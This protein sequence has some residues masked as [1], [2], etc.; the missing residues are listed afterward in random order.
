ME[1]KQLGKHCTFE[2][3]KQFDVLPFTCDACKKV[4][5]KEH[6]SIYAHRCTEGASRDVR[7]P[8]CPLC[9]KPVSCPKGVKPDNAIK[10]HIDNDCQSDSGKR[11]VYKYNCS[12]KECK[13]REIIALK[14]KDCSLNY[15]LIHRHSDDHKCS[16]KDVRKRRQSLEK[17]VGKHASNNVYVQLCSY[18]RAV[19]DE[20]KSLPNACPCTC[21]CH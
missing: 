4:Y 17:S 15:C 11:K 1:L 3:C 14:C 10:K 5:C 2:H 9:K 19:H 7:V 20:E 21:V 8:V 12:F 13:R 6:M 16:G 18:S